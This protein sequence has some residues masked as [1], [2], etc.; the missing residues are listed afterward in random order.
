MLN[1][2]QK[3]YNLYMDMLHDLI[4][5]K[6]IKEDEEFQELFNTL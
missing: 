6:F 2:S 1:K 4:K 3:Q 5:P